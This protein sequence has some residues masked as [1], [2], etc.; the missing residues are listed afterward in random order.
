MARGSHGHKQLTGTLSSYVAPYWYR[1]GSSILTEFDGYMANIYVVPK[2]S[3][4][5]AKQESISSALI[6]G[7]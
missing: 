2:E 6:C 4:P 5:M 7:G 1:R 3:P